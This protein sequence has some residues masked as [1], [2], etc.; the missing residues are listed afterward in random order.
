MMRIALQ[1]HVAL[2]ASTRVKVYRNRGVPV[3]EH[4]YLQLGLTSLH[5]THL[6]VIL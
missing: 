3:P 5:P 1:K 4:T 2:L 6:L